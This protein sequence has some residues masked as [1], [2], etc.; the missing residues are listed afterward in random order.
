MSGIKPVVIGLIAGALYT[1]AQAVFFPQG[2]NLGMFA[3]T[4][5]WLSLV[6]LA[7][8]ILLAVKKIHPITIIAVSAAL[9]IAFGYAD[10]LLI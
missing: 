6:I 4:A 5:I 2:L 10:K 7:L 3:D 9:G 8:D 1:T